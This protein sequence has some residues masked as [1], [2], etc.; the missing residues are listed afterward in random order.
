MSFL[1]KIK[2]AFSSDTK[3]EEIKDDANEKIEDVKE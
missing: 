2:G 3:R 1:D